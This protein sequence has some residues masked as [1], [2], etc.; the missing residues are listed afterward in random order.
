M[1]K[2]PRHWLGK[3][4]MAF[5][6]VLMIPIIASACISTGGIDLENYGG[7]W[8]P[9]DETVFT[10]DLGSIDGQTY[11]YDFG[12]PEARLALFSDSPY[13][14]IFFT[15]VIENGVS[16]WYADTYA[17]GQALL[18][19]ENAKFGISFTNDDETFLEYYVSGTSGAY[20]L[21]A[22][23]MDAPLLIHDAEKVH[24]PIPGAALLLGSG[25]FGLAAV[26]RK[27]RQV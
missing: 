20:A 1:K 17:G 15:E 5:L 13:A 12:A 14:N 3:I 16:S 18:L 21:M 24:T 27:S 19:G 23:G 9:T 4:V 7:A 26:R 2:H 10:M 22:S 25:L 6:L 11:I 8:E